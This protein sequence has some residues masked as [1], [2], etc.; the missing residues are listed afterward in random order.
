MDAGVAHPEL[1]ELV[2]AQERQRRLGF[3]GKYRGRVTELGSNRTGIENR[4]GQLKAAVPDVYGPEE[5]LRWANPAVPFAGNGHGH[6]ML[7]KVGD[8]VWIEF[9]AGNKDH[10]I[11]TGFFWAEDHELPD[12]V[13]A[14]VRT[15]QTPSGHKVILDDENNEI[16]L[17]HKDGQK[18]TL[19]RDSIKLEVASGSSLEVGKQS[20]KI[21]GSALEVKKQ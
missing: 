11:W 15:V 8:G 13:G 19:T 9:E 17:E 1:E 20:V 3:F 12:P 16:R 5:T 4:I 18:V 7:P 2:A 10:P 14:E 21:N 6:L